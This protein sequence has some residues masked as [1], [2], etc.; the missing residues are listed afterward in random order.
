MS[1]RSFVILI[2]LGSLSFSLRAAPPVP[3]TSPVISLDD[4]TATMY[5]AVNLEGRSGLVGFQI[6]EAGTKRFRRARPRWQKATQSP[7]AVTH[8]F[9]VVAIVKEDTDYEFRAV[10]IVRGV[11]RYGEVRSFHSS[12]FP[13]QI[14][15]TMATRIDN[16]TYVLSATINPRGRP[17]YAKFEWGTNTVNWLATP[18]QL[19]GAG[20]NPIVFQVVLIGLETNKLYLFGIQTW[21][22]LALSVHGGT[23]FTAPPLATSGVS[24]GGVILSRVGVMT[25]QLPPRETIP[26]RRIGLPAE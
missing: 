25:R 2:L 6:R 8:E 17:A 24:V 7:G 16:T 18:N 11:R 1:A 15:N 23:F 5:G 13:P 12:A 20:T 21:N 3:E 19:V 26:M 22:D 14:L 4:N 10:A 9:A